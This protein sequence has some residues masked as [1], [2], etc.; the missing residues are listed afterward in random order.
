MPDG[1]KGITTGYCVASMGFNL[2]GLEVL[3]LLGFQAIYGYLYYQLALLL[4]LTMGGM[5]VGSWWAL[6]VPLAERALVWLQIAAVASAPACCGALLVLAR[7]WSGAHWLNDSAGQAVFG[8]LALGAGLLAGL[9]FPAANRVLQGAPARAVFARVG[10]EGSPAC[11]VFARAGVGASQTPGRGS[12]LYALDLAGACAGAL[13]I[14]GY[15]VPVFGFVRAAM[16]LAV[17]AAGPVVPAAMG[18]WGKAR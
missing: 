10:V 4:A 5:A 3:L 12:R 16:V 7:F 8:V 17:V 9:Q 14:S 15:L 13:A 11:A 18:A 6:R 1:G 2:I